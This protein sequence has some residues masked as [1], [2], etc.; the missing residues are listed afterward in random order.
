M[1]VHSVIVMRVRVRG[2]E[3]ET[4]Y[5]RVSGVISLRVRVVRPVGSELGRIVSA[6]KAIKER[7][8]RVGGREDWVISRSPR[9]TRFKVFDCC[10]HWRLFRG[11]V[12]GITS[13][14]EVR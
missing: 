14:R 10:G 5:A 1:S 2:K 3:V 12:G 8:V 4:K 13:D 11:A 9:A 7:W 6:P